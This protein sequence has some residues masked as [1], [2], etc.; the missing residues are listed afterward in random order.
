MLPYIIIGDLKIPVFSFGLSIVFLVFLFLCIK[1]AEEKG[2]GEN[3]GIEISLLIA[4]STITFSKIPLG[5]IY[6]WKISS[7]LKFWETGHSLFS[8]LIIGTTIIFIYSKIKSVDFYELLSVLTYPTFF[9]LSLYRIFVCLPTGCCY[10]FPSRFGITFSQESYA[11]RDLGVAAAKLFPSQIIEAILFFICGTISYFKRKDKAENNIQLFLLLLTLERI[12][13]EFIRRDIKEK[14]IKAG[15]YGISVWLVLSIILFSATS[16][17]FNLLKPYIKS[18]REKMK[19]NGTKIFKIVAIAFLLFSQL[20][21]CSDKKSNVDFSAVENSLRS[22]FSLSYTAIFVSYIFLKIKGFLG[23]CIYRD[24]EN[25]IVVDCEF[26]VRILSA[27]KI[28]TRGTCD[29]SSFQNSI[30]FSN[31]KLQM[32]GTNFYG[33]ITGN[34]TLK[35]QSE[36]YIDNVTVSVIKSLYSNFTAEITETRSSLVSIQGESTRIFKISGKIKIEK[37][38]IS[39]EKIFLLDEGVERIGVMI[40]GSVSIKGCKNSNLDVKTE[41][42]VY[43]DEQGCPSGSAEIN[44]EKIYFSSKELYTQN[45]KLSSPCRGEKSECY[46]LYF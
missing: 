35:E 39:A 3:T 31:C 24:G 28:K 25:K 27:E 7:I 26:D 15:D 44:G 1:S 14:I 11:S 10:G 38:E 8:A 18:F 13:A 36:V 5:V 42:F 32:N 19:G 6:G 12:I 16:I 22:A 41:N 37:T 30:T 33:E 2:L 23:S 46:L 43:F 45:K 9:S 20:V 40:D 29:F 34:T 21:M 4:F 17:Y